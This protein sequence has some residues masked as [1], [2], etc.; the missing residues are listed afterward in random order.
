V[1]RRRANLNIKL[2]PELDEIED[3]VPKPLIFAVVFTVIGR[4]SD[5]YASHYNPIYPL[6]DPL[7]GWL[8]Q[9]HL[10]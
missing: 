4:G 1:D 9:L 2:L 10:R 8:C 3:R 6:F 7:S 5:F